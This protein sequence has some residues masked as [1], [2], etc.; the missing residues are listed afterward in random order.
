MV[1]HPMLIL[2]AGMGIIVLTGSAF[3]LRRQFA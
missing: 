1:I 2:A 3:A